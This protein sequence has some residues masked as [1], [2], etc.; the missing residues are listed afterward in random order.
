MTSL[1]SDVGSAS[2]HAGYKLPGLGL[3]D[4]GGLVVRRGVA[5]CGGRQQAGGAVGGG[6]GC[7]VCRWITDYNAGYDRMNEDRDRVTGSTFARR[8]DVGDVGRGRGGGRVAGG[9]VR[10]AAAAEAVPQAGANLASGGIDIGNRHV[11]GG[12]GVGLDRDAVAFAIL[13]G[14][15]ER[16]ANLAVAEGLAIGGKRWGECDG[17]DLSDF[18][19]GV[20]AIA[21]DN[22]Q[23]LFAARD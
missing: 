4:A 14:G 8:G 1:A 5:G 18:R 20:A 10:D 21:I 6:I 3:R 2:V 16:L 23:R 13:C 12:V 11:A 7:T 17:C 19:T 9:V 22:R 15:T